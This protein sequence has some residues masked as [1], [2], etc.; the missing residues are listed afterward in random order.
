[1]N[2]GLGKAEKIDPLTVRW[3]RHQAHDDEAESHKMDRYI[4]IDQKRGL[5]K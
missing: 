1:M 3:T 4:T 2:F 5:V